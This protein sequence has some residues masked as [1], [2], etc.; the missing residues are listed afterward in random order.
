MDDFEDGVLPMV[1]SS[2]GAPADQLYHSHLRHSP[3]WPFLFLLFFPL[4]VVITV[5]LCTVFTRKADG[6]L[7]FAD[8]TQRR[9]R[10]SRRA[11]NLTA[12]VGLGFAVLAIVGLVG[13]QIV[14][15]FIAMLVVGALV[16]VGGL[17]RAAVPAGSI[18]GKPDSNGRW[19]TLSGVSHAFADAYDMQERRRR[20][21]RRAE[22]T[23]RA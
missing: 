22:V 18:G 4:G 23:D 9:M 3:A 13:H 6:L 14:P 20:A 21:E 2:S 1:C 15:V 12:G 8:E 10:R 19:I 16:V 11:A 17:I 5:V 7:P